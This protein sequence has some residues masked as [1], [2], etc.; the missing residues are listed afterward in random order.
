MVIVCRAAANVPKRNTHKSSGFSGYFRHQWCVGSHFY[1][2]TPPPPPR[3]H[4]STV[5]LVANGTTVRR[6]V[7]MLSSVL[8]VIDLE[9]RNQGDEIRFGGFDL[10]HAGGTTFPSTNRTGDGSSLYTT[11][12]GTEIPQQRVDRMLRN[13]DT[14][15]PPSGPS[16][17]NATDGSSRRHSS[18][19]WTTAGA[20]TTGGEA[21][22]GGGGSASPARGVSGRCGGGGG[23]GA[24]GGSS[25]SGSSMARGIRT[26]SSDSLSRDS[27]G[28]GRAG[29]NE[30]GIRGSSSRGGDRSSAGGGGGHSGGIGSGSSRGSTGAKGGKSGER[31]RDR[32]RGERNGRDNRHRDRGER[33][34]EKRGGKSPTRPV[35]D[36]AAGSL[37]STGRGSSSD[38]E[39]LLTA[40]VR[41]GNHSC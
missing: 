12:L 18:S 29:R 20:G 13:P 21:G 34:D 10:I 23:G 4:L 38:S 36:G 22:G 40:T 41:K 33:V 15:L 14:S 35:E 8:D 17:G 1:L 5:S 26:S 16:G 9:G 37:P 25:G 3:D 2:R 19:L 27:R 24:S 32:D 28:E 7:A 11:A 31:D 30:A 39:K 6:Q